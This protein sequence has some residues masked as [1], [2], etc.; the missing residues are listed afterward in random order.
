MAFTNGKRLSPVK[1]VSE[2]ETVEAPYRRYLAIAAILIVG[3][4]QFTKILAVEK[5]EGRAPIELF[6]TLQLNTT[7]NKGAS[8]SL[9]TEYTSLLAVVALVAMILFGVVLGGVLGN[10]TD[11]IF[12]SSNGLL[13]GGVVDFIDFQWWPIFNVA[14]M[15]LVLGL[16]SL[17]IMMLKG[18]RES[19]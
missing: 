16:P 4:D 19:G 11:R 3:L 8:F 1:I 9:G 6:W 18:G 5:L 12:R 7:R 2:S 15:A 17:G 14:D 10:V 13:N